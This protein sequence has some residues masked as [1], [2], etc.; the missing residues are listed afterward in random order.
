MPAGEIRMEGT[1]RLRRT[2]RAGG[3]DLSDMRAAHLDAA[4]IAA[5][6]SADLAPVGPTGRLQNSIRPAGTKTAGII[7]AGTKR[8]PY[9]GVIH[10]GWGRRHI[11]SQPFLSNGARNS[12][13]RWI[14][15][16]SDYLDKA[17][18]QIKGI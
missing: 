11:K 17:L 16:Y 2:L 4:T 12:E 13:G 7:R 14:R 9:A 6:A 3:D 15:V 5:N 8:V 18:D 10:W 1:R